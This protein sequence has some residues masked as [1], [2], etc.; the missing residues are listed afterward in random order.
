[1]WF[2]QQ[3]RLSWAEIGRRLG[4]DHLPSYSQP[5]LARVSTRSYMK[6]RGVA[7]EGDQVNLSVG[8]NTITLTVTSAD[9]RATGTYMVTVTR[10]AG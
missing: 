8:A 6:R 3:S 10:E 2:Q 4:I 1:M 9:G 7:T 5:N